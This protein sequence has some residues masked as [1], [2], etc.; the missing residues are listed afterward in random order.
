MNEDV[1][2]LEALTWASSFLEKHQREAYVANVLLAYHLQIDPKDLHETMQDHLTASVYNAFKSDIIKHV[3]TGIP[4]QHIT[5]EAYFYG[6]SFFVNEHV[7]IPRYDTEFVLQAVIDHVKEFPLDE[8]IIADIGTG[9]GI[10]AITLALELPQATIYATDISEE[11]LIIAAENARKHDAN[12]NFLQ[13]SF[14]EP[15]IEKKIHPTIVVSNPPY[16][17]F[18]HEAILAD[19]VKDYDPP[20]A[21]YSGET[22]LEAYEKMTDQV[23]SLS[24]Q[25][26]VLAYEIGF[27]QGD[28]VKEIIENKFPSSTPVILND[29]QGN[30]RVVFAHLKK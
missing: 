10:I 28:A 15:L 14:I 18:G 27:D 22:G 7:L 29:F 25:P 26:E 5:K 24:K 4:V 17:P 30:E 9:S 13:G 1:K 6:R 16:I 21:L 11:A 19:T 20:T 3:Q 2:Q 12:I 8:V 23:T